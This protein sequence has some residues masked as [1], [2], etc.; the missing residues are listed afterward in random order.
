MSAVTIVPY[1]QVKEER[2]NGLSLEALKNPQCVHRLLQHH[3]T[4]TEPTIRTQK[5][6]YTECLWPSLGRYSKMP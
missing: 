1:V 6:Q 5:M 3:G 4:I 2:I